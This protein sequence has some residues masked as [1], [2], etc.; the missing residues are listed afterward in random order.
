MIVKR[1]DAEV[2]ARQHEPLAPPIENRKSKHAVQPFETVSP[3]AFV[4]TKNHF[5][6]CLRPEP[7]A[8]LFKLAAQLDKVVDL[9]VKSNPERFVFVAHRLVTRRRQIDDAQAAM[10]QTDALRRKFTHATIIRT[11]MRLRVSHRAQ[12]VD[13][14][15]IN[16]S[17]YPAHSLLLPSAGCSSAVSS[18]SSRRL[19]AHMHNAPTPRLRMVH[20]SEDKQTIPSSA[21]SAPT[22][23]NN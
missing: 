5:R 21:A 22:A 14:E 8:L 10:S 4:E 16:C 11:T 6:V 12:A 9:A 13:A 15:G 17:G 7:A 18:A 1:L 2:I 3:L 23:A 20:P 19:F